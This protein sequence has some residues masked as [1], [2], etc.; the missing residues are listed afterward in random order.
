M[1]SIFSR[2][3]KNFFKASHILSH[4]NQQANK[5][6]FITPHRYHPQNTASYAASGEELIQA[7][8][9]VKSVVSL[10]A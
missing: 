2:P 5:V 9:E 7:T 1:N 8:S 10:A 6:R 4:P 3:M